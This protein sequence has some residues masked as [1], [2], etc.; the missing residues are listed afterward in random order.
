MDYKKI[1][2]EKLISPQKAAGF[3]KDGMTIDFGWG[4]SISQTFD[5]ALANDL[6][7]LNE[8]TVCA[9]V[10]LRK[11][12]IFDADPDGK[13]VIWNSY[14]SGGPDRKRINAGEGGFY[15]PLRYSE[16]PRWIR[17]NIDVDIAIVV[18][19]P[20]N[21]H[22]YFNFGISASHEMALIE[23]AKLVIVE[24]NKNLSLIHI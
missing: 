2:D 18:A 11:P 22:G 10:V 24:V 23:K 13:K 6:E 19:S 16:L 17:E 7:R 14:H 3:V 9:G 20:M 15:V 21:K 12:S 4:A 5:K 8:I 1:Y